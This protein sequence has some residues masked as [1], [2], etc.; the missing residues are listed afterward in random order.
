MISMAASVALR[1]QPLMAEPRNIRRKA[2]LETSCRVRVH[3]RI[4]YRD[5]SRF[6]TDGQN[7]RIVE[8]EIEK[9]C[10]QGASAL[11]RLS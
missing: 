9:Q 4:E 2:H 6:G 3:V 10:K 5:R 11:G 7:E 1:L 8:R